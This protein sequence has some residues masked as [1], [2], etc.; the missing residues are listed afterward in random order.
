MT[1]LLN[2]GILSLASVRLA[3]VSSLIGIIMILVGVAGKNGLPF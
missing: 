1:K 3:E 2:N